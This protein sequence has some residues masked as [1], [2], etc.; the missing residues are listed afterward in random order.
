MS[1]FLSQE[2]MSVRK[3]A[4]EENCPR[5]L[6]PE[7]NCPP[8]NCP[9]DDCPQIIAPGQLPKDNCSLTISLWKLLPRKIVF[10]MICRLHNSPSEKLPQGKLRPLG[11]LSQG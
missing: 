4:P 3:I 8:N 5:P 2:K 6:P 10:W 9:L 7:E 11:K 1:I